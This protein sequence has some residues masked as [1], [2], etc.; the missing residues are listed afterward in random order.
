M[1]KLIIIFCIGLATVFTS[2]ENQFDPASDNHLTFDE[3]FR[4]PSFAEGLLINGYTNLPQ[5][6]YSSDVATDNAVSNNKDDSYRQMAIGGW[7]SNYSPVSQWDQCYKAILYLNKMLVTVKDIN[8]A[9]IS[10]DPYNSMYI[11][12]HT[13]EAY[14]LRAYYM[15]YLLQAHAGVGI[16][17]KLLGVPIITD[18][19]DG[20]IAFDTPRNTF[21][22][23]VNQIYSDIE[24]AEELLP[25]DFKNITNEDDMITVCKDLNASI[26]QYNSIFG[27]KTQQRI[28][29]RILKGLKSRV[30]LLAA[31]PAYSTGTYEDAAKYAADVLNLI[32][33]VAG[34]DPTGN[35]YYTA[36]NIDN[37]DV[38][39]LPDK[40]EI[41]WRGSIYTNSWRETDQF[42]PTLYGKGRIN[43]TENLVNAFPDAN[44]YPITSSA[45]NYDSNHPYDNRDPRL[46]EYII[47]NGSTFSGHTIDIEN[48][49]GNDA[50]NSMAYSTRTGYYLRKC[51]REDT[52]LD[53]NI[54]TSQKTYNVYMR[55]T[56]IFLNYA[57]AMNEV[58]GPD[59]TGPYGYSAR[60]VIRAIRQR[61]G[62]PSDDPYLNNAT[63][64]EFTELIKNERRIEL[65]FEGFR[66]W[67]LRR[68]KENLNETANG[69]TINNGTITENTVEERN[70]SDYMYYG[71]IPYQE[72]LKY[73]LT[74][75]A[76]W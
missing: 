22:E 31:S 25:L 54:N 28:S 16:D 71:P 19:Y 30:A 53:P 27:T 42:P 4:D 65:C 56:E 23:C 46:S 36:S 58:Y 63:D 10:G 59:G 70:Y 69:I 60:D 41:L 2:C 34:L 48:G 40:P 44:G 74:Q 7:T 72:A 55:Y 38:N 51:L 49:S 50:V 67:D 1:K 76:G 14:G 47:Y 62:I 26:D 11:I 66:F 9:P 8:W 57:E 64:E 20:D 52:N 45:S 18:S 13:G 15:Y 37:L 3:V 12:R 68:W 17:G 61:A 33:G 6:S 35:I 39:S 24:K 29:S 73:N 32:G 5:Y 21:E 75:N 43:P